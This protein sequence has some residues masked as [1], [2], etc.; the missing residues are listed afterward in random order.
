[1]NKALLAKAKAAAKAEGR[2]LSNWLE[3]I[4]K[5]GIPLI[6]AGFLVIH[7]CRPGSKWTT[8]SL[9]ATVEAGIA[10]VLRP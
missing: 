7:Y 9:S 4:V 6:V 8:R 10:A 1:M 2:S 3:Q 5:K